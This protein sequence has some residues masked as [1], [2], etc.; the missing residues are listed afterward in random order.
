MTTDE[1]IYKLLNRGYPSGFEDA[2]VYR[3]NRSKDR[4]REDLGT[5]RYIYACTYRPYF[6]VGPLFRAEIEEAEGIEYD[7]RAATARNFVIGTRE[8]LSYR[9][10]ERCELIEL[11]AAT[12][13]G[14]CRRQWDGETALC[15][16]S[17]DRKDIKILARSAYRGHDFQLSH[18]RERLGPTRHDAGD[19][20]E[21][22]RWFRRLLRDEWET[23]PSS[24]VDRQVSAWTEEGMA[25]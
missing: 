24:Y 12:R 16:V 22:E 5:A 23:A 6:G 10:I 21:V 17:P 4:M 9:A 19:W 1:A 13:A 15:F 14:T 18:F 3:F 11:D 8:P 25:A 20:S 7:L 2:Q